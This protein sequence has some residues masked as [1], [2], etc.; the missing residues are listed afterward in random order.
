MAGIK[1]HGGRAVDAMFMEFSK[2]E[3][4][5]VFSRIMPGKLAAT[6]KREALPD[7][8]L[9][10]EKRCG[11]LKGRTCTDSTT[12]RKHYTKEETS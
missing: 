4:K 2:L 8:N 1:K 7:V 6:Q 12:Q 3:D 5:S 9:I 10:I 11:K